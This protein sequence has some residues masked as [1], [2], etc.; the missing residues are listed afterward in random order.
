MTQFSHASRY[1]NNADVYKLSQ[2]YQKFLFEQF[3][4]WIGFVT[5]INTSEET[6]GASIANQVLVKDYMQ[7]TSNSI[8][9]KTTDANP[10]LFQVGT[11]NVMLFHEFYQELVRQQ[12]VDKIINLR[13][14]SKIR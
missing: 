14:F 10:R 13:L 1:L 4:V 11:V 9:E 7:E 6:Q 12:A 2:E 3:K 8:Y 5:A